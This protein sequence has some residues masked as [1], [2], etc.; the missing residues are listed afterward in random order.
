MK[1][2]LDNLLIL[3]ENI[4]KENVEGLIPADPKDIDARLAALFD[5][6]K[7]GIIDFSHERKTRVFRYRKSCPINKLI[8]LFSERLKELYVDH[9]TKFKDKIY[10]LEFSLALSMDE[11]AK[12]IILQVKNE[13]IY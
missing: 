6:E 12:T 11:L 5:H 3:A 7:F 13:P 1:P 4:L 8:S 9:D 2:N 10:L